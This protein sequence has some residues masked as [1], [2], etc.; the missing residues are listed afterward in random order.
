M[1]HIP[2]FMCLFLWQYCH[3]ADDQ[4]PSIPE[5]PVNSTDHEISLCV[6]VQTPHNQD[7]EEQTSPSIPRLDFTDIPRN[8]NPQSTG[9]V[10]RELIESVQKDTP[11]TAMCNLKKYETIITCNRTKDNKG[12]N[13]FQ[14]ALLQNIELAEFIVDNTPWKPHLSHRNNDGQDSYELIV[15]YETSQPREFAIKL[16]LVDT[17]DEAKKK[18]AFL[19]I[20]ENEPN[21][22]YKRH[23]RTKLL[24]SSTPNEATDTN[25]YCVLLGDALNYCIRNRLSEPES[26][27]TSEEI[28]GSIENIGS[29]NIHPVAPQDPRPSL[30][31]SISIKI[32]ELVKSPRDKKETT[33]TKRTLPFAAKSKPSS[34]SFSGQQDSKAS[35]ILSLLRR[36]K[37]DVVN[38]SSHPPTTESPPSTPT[39]PSEKSKKKKKGKGK[40]KE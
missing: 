37:S 6:E 10:R 32:K 27:H 3:A 30:D 9:S 18:E 35:K 4:M 20:L 16:S 39:S 14:I 17:F 11:H 36:N 38:T 15:Q 33:S 28:N 5:L 23:L 12:N 40:E 22:E 25:T 26:P 29:W 8:S 7:P 1:I 13:L 2:F 21:E 31:R 34:S 24:N 19:K